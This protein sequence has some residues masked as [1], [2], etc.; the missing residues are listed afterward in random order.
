MYR[1]TQAPLDREVAVKLLVDH[2]D[3]DRVE[4]HRQR[5]SLE[6][7][8]AARL[9]HP[10]TIT[11]F[12][13]GQVLLDGQVTFYIAM[14]LLPGQTLT[15]ALRGTRFHPARALNVS[16]QICRALREAHRAGVV[17][18]DLKPGNIM[19]QRPNDDAS[20]ADADF[21]KVL[22]FGLVKTF[23]GGEAL[24]KAGTFLGSPRYVSPEQVEG[25]PIDARSDIYSFGV[26]LYRM[27]SGRVPF[28]GNAP[29][30]I[31]LM[32]LD[33]TPP[34]LDVD[35]L[36]AGLEDLV[37]RCLEKDVAL[38]PGD[39]DEVIEQLKRAQDDLAPPDFNLTSESIFHDDDHEDHDEAAAT[40]PTVREGA[41]KSRR[42]IDPE[43]RTVRRRAVAQG[44][45]PATRQTLSEDED[46]TG[47]EP[48]LLMPP[49]RH[50]TPIWVSVLVGGLLATGLIVGH[51][52]GALDSLFGQAAAQQLRDVEIRVLS[53]PSRAKVY[54]LKPNGKR[55]V[56]LGVTPLKLHRTL[57][58]S[59]P[60]FELLLKKRGYKNS[61]VKVAPP[62]A[63]ATAPFVVQVTGKLRRR[64]K[65]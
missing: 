23:S 12:D 29:I 63:Q 4:E 48:T 1:A 3:P 47:N 13:Y 28:E 14:E 65:R 26:V 36:P 53:K 60:P 8:T 34:P 15:Q 31:M 5:F 21:V 42:D 17:H 9:N 44:D 52:S 56:F 50:R 25:R 54:A 64:S 16:L 45:P 58:A 2:P 10:N 32:H 18:R 30:D 19:L 61:V 20:Q 57:K 43:G 55:G 7:A 39:M 38:R 51:Q 27:L 6:A 40:N 37:M 11:I 62:N 24:T 49:S 35:G 22:D 59:D 33:D 46:P 41:L